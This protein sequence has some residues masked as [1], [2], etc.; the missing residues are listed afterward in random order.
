MGLIL[1][2]NFIITAEREA[3][4]GSSVRTDTFLA[5]HA[6]EKVFITFTI[7]DEF[8]CGR[9]ATARRE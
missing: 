9:S 6:D 3:K 1:D 4:G 7:A 8:A 2:T 5:A